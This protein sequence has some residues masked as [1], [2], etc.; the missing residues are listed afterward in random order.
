MFLR[1]P[2]IVA[3]GSTTDAHA[4]RWALGAGMNRM[5]ETSGS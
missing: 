5:L 2:L 4:R 1:I 3:N